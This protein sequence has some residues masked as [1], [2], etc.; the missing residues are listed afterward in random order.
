MVQGQTKL[1]SG[2]RKQKSDYLIKKIGYGL[3]EARNLLS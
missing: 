2:I 3:K 1:I